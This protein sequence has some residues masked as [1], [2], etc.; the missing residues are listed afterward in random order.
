M[1]GTSGLQGMHT[2]FLADH[3]NMQFSQ[4]VFITYGEGAGIGFTGFE[5]SFSIMRGSQ[6]QDLA[7]EFL[8]FMLEVY[9]CF[10]GGIDALLGGIDAVTWPNYG[11]GTFAFPV[12]RARFDNQV[13]SVMW[14]H[15]HNAGLFM[16]ADA[17]TAFSA[18]R[19][20]HVAAAMDDLRDMME[21]LNHEI[22]V[23]HSVLQSLIYPDIW[24]LLTGRQD[25]ALT[26]ERIHSRLVLYVHE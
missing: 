7:W 8:R 3:T 2:L 13:R 23:D 19:P 17:R 1:M 22:R 14:H 12:N 24:L 5:S 4:P 26:L 11:P 10:M 21:Q 18:A 9:E 16:P 20:A 6:N 15:H 25:V